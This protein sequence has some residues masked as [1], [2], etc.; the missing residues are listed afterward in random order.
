MVAFIEDFH[1]GAFI[2][3]EMCCYGDLSRE[4]I[5]VAAG[6]TLK[7]GAVLGFA[8]TAPAVP[9]MVGTGNAVMSA[10]SIG[11]KV[12]PGNYVVKFTG[13]TTYTVTAP[14]GEMLPAAAALGAYASSQIGWTI[15]A[16]AT[17]AVAGDTFTVVVP[18]TGKYKEYN[19]ANTDG[20]Q[21]ARAVLFAPVNA[22][23]G[24]MPGT[25][26]V[27]LAEVKKA[28]LTWFAGASAPQQAAG[29]ADLATVSIIAR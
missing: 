25:A 13:A 28:A 27:R 24:D 18:A 1:A 14:D 21:V 23:A 9:A 7:A 4:A 11:P 19:P 29:L 10:I 8:N 17:A 12:Q 22:A 3:S 20:S 15:T 26:V 5:V 6:Q 2:Q 16:G